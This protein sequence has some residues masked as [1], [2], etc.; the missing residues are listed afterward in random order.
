MSAGLPVAGKRKESRL[1]G[2]SSFS[3]LCCL[4]CC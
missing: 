4:G 2:G 3:T 1:F